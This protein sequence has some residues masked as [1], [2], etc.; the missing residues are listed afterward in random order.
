M[1]SQLKGHEM[2]PKPMLTNK[3]HRQCMKS[4]AEEEME[5]VG[6]DDPHANYEKYEGARNTINLIHH[7]EYLQKRIRKL[8]VEKKQS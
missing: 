3:L 2:I 6:H 7:I 5:E 8:E 4:I 1:D